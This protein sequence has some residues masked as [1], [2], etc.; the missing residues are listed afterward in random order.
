M[1]FAFDVVLAYKQVQRG[2]VE[3]IVGDAHFGEGLVGGGK[4]GVG[5]GGVLEGRVEDCRAAGGG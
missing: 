5:C 3:G 4:A 1:T 2:Y